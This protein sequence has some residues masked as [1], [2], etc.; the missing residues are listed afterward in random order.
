MYSRIRVAI[1]VAVLLI[2]AAVLGIMFNSNA[3][4]QES[5]S[6]RV[7]EGVGEYGGRCPGEKAVKRCE[8]EVNRFSSVLMTDSEYDMLA[9]VIYDLASGKSA[10]EQRRV[11]EIVLNRVISGKYP[12]TVSGVIRDMEPCRQFD[13]PAQGEHEYQKSIIDYVLTAEPLTECG[14]YFY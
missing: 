3:A 5:C 8:W 2:I 14:C 10:E 12:D 7:I 6:R 9:G 13:T 11:C 1:T 4:D